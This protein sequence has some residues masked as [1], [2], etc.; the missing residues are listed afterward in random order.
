[1]SALGVRRLE[2]AGFSVFWLSTRR[3][4]RELREREEEFNKGVNHYFEAKNIVR[5]PNQPIHTLN[6]T[7]A[8]TAQQSPIPP[9][10]QL[11]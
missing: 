6:P 8:I 5:S 11:P 2:L 4:H 3:G 1:M 10:P 9:T 7:L